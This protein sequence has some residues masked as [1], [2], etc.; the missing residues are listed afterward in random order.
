M[1]TPFVW[2]EGGAVQETLTEFELVAEAEISPGGSEG[3]NSE[4]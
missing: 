4:Q 1:R 3:T 2:S